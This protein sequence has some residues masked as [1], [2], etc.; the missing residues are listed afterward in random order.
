M[1]LDK[2]TARKT[3]LAKRAA[4]DPVLKKEK[5][6]RITARVI[7]KIRDRNLV[8]CYVSFGNEA[9]THEIIRWCFA[10]QVK[11]AV[12]KVTGKMLVFHIITSFDDLQPGTMGILEPAEDNPVQ[13]QDIDFMIV[14]LTA[15]DGMNHRVGYGGGYYD[16][17]LGRCAE[18]A[19]IAFSEQKTELIDIDSWDV[20]PQEIICE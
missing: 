9:D 3:A 13:L 12:P 15:F 2:K 11:V 6:A 4:M 7:E 1:P 14:P 17:I 16:R 8:G 5:E 10:N 19:A 18:N 20:S